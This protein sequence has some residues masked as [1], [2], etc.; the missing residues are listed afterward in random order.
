MY[1]SGIMYVFLACIFSGMMYVFCRVFFSG[2][3][4]VFGRF[5]SVASRGARDATY[6]GISDNEIAL[7]PF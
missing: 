7:L 3:M 5:M 4:Y 2:I 1:F 6:R